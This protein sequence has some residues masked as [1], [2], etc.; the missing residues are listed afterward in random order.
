MSQQLGLA[1]GLSQTP[2][3]S[4]P[5]PA[6]PLH[7]LS[8]GRRP[9][10]SDAPQRKGPAPPLSS[11]QRAESEKQGEPRKSCS[12]DSTV[13][14]L[15]GEPAFFLQKLRATEGRMRRGSRKPPSSETQ[16]NDRT[17]RHG[18][19]TSSSLINSGQPLGGFDERGTKPPAEAQRVGCPRRVGPPQS[20]AAGS[21]FLNLSP[22]VVPGCRT[23]TRSRA[24]P[25]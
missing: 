13:R 24:S 2:P 14:N 1:R 15:P 5:F 18:G 3:Y 8:L 9:F 11:G 17:G 6:F 7:L 12:M 23:H 20:K 19:G 21:S 22:T 16:A 10:L 4:S 25:K